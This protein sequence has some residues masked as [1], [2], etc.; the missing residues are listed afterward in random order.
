MTQLHEQGLKGIYVAIYTPT[1][2]NK[3]NMNTKP[4]GGVNL[5]TI[6]MA[7]VGYQ[8]YPPKGTEHYKLLQ[9]RQYNIGPHRGYFLKEVKLK[10]TQD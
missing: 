6:N 4:R 1:D 2:R 8:H 9:L 10:S 5:Q 3:A 7:I